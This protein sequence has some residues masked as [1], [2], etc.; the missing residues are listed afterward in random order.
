MGG[1]Q[2]VPRYVKRGGACENGWATTGGEALE[3][4]PVYYTKNR[5]VVVIVGKQPHDA[6]QVTHMRIKLARFFVQKSRR[7]GGFTDNIRYI[8]DLR[9]WVSHGRSRSVLEASR[10]FNIYRL[11]PPCHSVERQEQIRVCVSNDAL[12][13]ANKPETHNPLKKNLPQHLLT[14]DLIV[15]I[16]IG[17]V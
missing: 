16:M 15:L 4:V 14:L 10:R 3:F 5:F 13:S 6:L 9:V 11:L 1:L 12:P 8:I 7:S 17:D 2:L